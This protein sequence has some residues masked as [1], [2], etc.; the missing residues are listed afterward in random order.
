MSNYLLMPDLFRGLKG[1]LSFCCGYFRKSTF[2]KSVTFHF[3]NQPHWC[4]VVVPQTHPSRRIRWCSAHI[5]RHTHILQRAPSTLLQHCSACEAGC[6]PVLYCEGH[7]S[8]SQAQGQLA[9]HLKESPGR[10]PSR[11]WWLDNADRRQTHPWE[12][13]KLHCQR[14]PRQIWN[15]GQMWGREHSHPREQWCW[16]NMGSKTYPRG[17]YPLRVS[18]AKLRVLTLIRLYLLGWYWWGELGSTLEKLFSAAIVSIFTQ[19]SL[20]SFSLL[21]GWEKNV[22]DKTQ[23]EQK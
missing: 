18:G 15:K 10:M 23:R 4:T 8:P 11:G 13:H 5:L 17:D 22:V 12:K 9:L 20:V 16:K 21:V 1:L 6:L 14:W 19:P 3:W 2:H 7:M